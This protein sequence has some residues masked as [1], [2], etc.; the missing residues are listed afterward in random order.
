MLPRTCCQK[1]SGE[2]PCFDHSVQLDHSLLLSSLRIVSR[3]SVLHIVYYC[4]WP[5]HFVQRVNPNAKKAKKIVVKKSGRML[6]HDP[7]VVDAIVDVIIVDVPGVLSVTVAVG[8]TAVVGVVRL[9][10]NIVV[11]VLVVVGEVYALAVLPVEAGIVVV[12]VKVVVVLAVLLAVLTRVVVVLTGMVV[13]FSI[14]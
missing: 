3:T 11:E 12:L 6:L 1:R 4:L 7:V 9:V 10:I 14:P 8:V 13:G 5:S 2:S